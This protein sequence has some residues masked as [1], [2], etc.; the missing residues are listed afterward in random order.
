MIRGLHCYFAICCLFLPDHIYLNSQIVP[1]V[2]GETSTG[3]TRHAHIAHTALV[4]SGERKHFQNVDRLDLPTVTG[5]RPC[6]ARRTGLRKHHQPRLPSH[7]GLSCRA[8]LQANHGTISRLQVYSNNPRKLRGLVPL[9][10][11]YDQVYF[12]PCQLGRNIPHRRSEILHLLEVAL[13]CRQ[14]GRLLHHLQ[15]SQDPPR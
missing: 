2:F 14:Q 10:G 7:N 5:T 3:R 9:L 15:H 13:C 11:K 12:H 1:P 4:R 8:L 6:D